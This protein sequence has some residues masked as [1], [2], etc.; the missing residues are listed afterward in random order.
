MSVQLLHAARC[1][2]C[3]RVMRA[4]TDVEWITEAD[5]RYSYVHEQCPEGEE[6]ER[7]RRQQNAAQPRDAE[8]RFRF[9]DCPTCGTEWAVPKGETIREW[10]CCNWKETREAQ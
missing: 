6:E 2:E 8:E 7:P 5:G 1:M 9:E 10:R 3:K 4:G